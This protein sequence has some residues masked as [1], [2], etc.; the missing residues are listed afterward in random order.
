LPNPYR[1][2]ERYPIVEDK[3]ANLVASI[4]QTTF[5][6]NLL[7]RKAPGKPGKY[8]LAYGVHRREALKRARI[9]EIDIPVRALDDA[10]MI[11]IMA[12]ENMEEWGHSAAIE[13]ET[14]RAVVEGYANSKFE[15]PM[16]TRRNGPYYDAASD[17]PFK[18]HEPDSRSSESPIRPYNVEALISFLGW[19]R[20]KI[21]AAIGSLGLI[22]ERLIDERSLASL[23]SRQSQVVT[24]QVRRVVRETSQ[25]TLAR[26][27][28]RRIA[29]G[30]RRSVSGHDRA[31]N[32][33]NVQDVT[34]HNARA[35]VDEMI[36]P[37]VPRQQP[38]RTLP[39][40][41]RFIEALVRQMLDMPSDQLKTKVDSVIAARGDIPAREVR[42]LISALKGVAKR[43]ERM[44]EKLEA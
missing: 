6:D 2:L 5:W 24:E 35:R 38:Q 26:E 30:M 41:A 40:A 15:L 11:R 23:T 43:F 25:P 44:A 32:E 34:I 33:R 17:L 29:A 14:I 13:Q 19:K 8:E 1:H 20:Y 7:A 39:D 4:N 9:T 3:V 31:G 28:G 21:E 12:N 37:H 10:T 27:V 18:Q 16:A 36:A 42:H 22:S